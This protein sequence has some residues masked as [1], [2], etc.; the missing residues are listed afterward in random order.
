ML[1]ALTTEMFFDYLAIRLDSTKVEGVEF[2]ANVYHPDTGDK[3]IVELSN[4][5]LTTRAGFSSP[6]PDLTLTVDRSVFEE[7]LTGQSTDMGLVADGRATLEGDP[8]HFEV[9]YGA[10]AEFDLLFEL[11]PGTESK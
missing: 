5:T 4:A 1:R 3:L 8:S 9:F 6:Q 11:I 10:L 2:V 7:V